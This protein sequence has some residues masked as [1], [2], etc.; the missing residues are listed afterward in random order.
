MSTHSILYAHF[1]IIFIGCVTV[2]QSV[3]ELIACLKS[4][5][6]PTRRKVTQ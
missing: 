6:L 3:E 4:D 1:K 5:K 2:L